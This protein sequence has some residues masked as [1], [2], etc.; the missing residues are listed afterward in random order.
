MKIFKKVFKRIAE[1]F[2]GT[3]EERFKVSLI[4][5]MF[6]S[7]EKEGYTYKVDRSGIRREKLIKTTGEEGV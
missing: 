1:L 6:E 7:A 3:P 5:K 2:I 4:K